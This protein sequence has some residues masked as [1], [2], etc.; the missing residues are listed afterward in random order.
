MPGLGRGP[1]GRGGNPGVAPGRGVAAGGR[2]RLAGLTPKGLLPG[3]GPGR[4]G[5]R[6]GIPGVSASGGRTARSAGTV[7]PG[8]GVLALAGAAGRARTGPGTAGEG[9][10]GCWPTAGVA[11]AGVIT[12]GV[13]PACAA[14]TGDAVDG[15]AL[16][17]LTGAGAVVAGAPAVAG[18]GAGAAGAAP[19]NA[20]LS[21]RATGA[22]TV[23]DADLTNSPSSL[24][25][26]MTSLLGTPSSLASSCTRALPA[27]GLLIRS[28]AADPRQLLRYWGSLLIASTSSS[29]HRCRPAFGCRT[30][31]RVPGSC[32]IRARLP[33]GTG[34][35]VAGLGCCAVLCC[36]R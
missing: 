5:G 34:V 10:P 27:T 33:G 2:G 6:G 18:R 22:S 15:T 29:A 3:R 24:S 20:S 17:G 30:G 1:P 36:A 9:A 26:V 31:G 23:D 12:V 13:L 4:A 11:A 16:T 7:G 28:R 32:S 19:G 21:R 35:A 8:A 14:V 25:L